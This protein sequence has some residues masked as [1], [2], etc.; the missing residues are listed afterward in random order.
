[1]S[2]PL[3][4]PGT[5]SDQSLVSVDYFADVVKAYR[6]EIQ[7]LYD[8]GCRRIQ[9][10]DAV[11]CF[12]CSDSMCSSI[13]AMGFDHGKLLGTYI[14]VYNAVTADRPRDLIFGVHTCRGNMKVS[15]SCILDG[16][17]TNRRSSGWRS[18]ADSSTAVQGNQIGILCEMK[19]SGEGR[20]VAMSENLY[21]TPARA[22]LKSATVDARSPSSQE[23]LYDMLALRY[24]YQDGNSAGNPGG[25]LG[26]AI[27]GKSFACEIK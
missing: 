4:G 8:H 13:E 3:Y 5:H 24:Q 16:G 26:E 17:G 27:R 21:N 18:V 10:D 15:A 22:Q 25:G 6:E 20:S 11:F 19:K 14:E 9:F 12:L 7:D 2:I 23:G 1:M